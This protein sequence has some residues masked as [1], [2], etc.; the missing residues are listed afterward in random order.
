MNK[1]L[2]VFLC[3]PLQ[4]TI[5]NPFI[6]SSLSDHRSLLDLSLISKLL[7][8][9]PPTVFLSF[10]SFVAPCYYNPSFFAAVSPLR[11]QCTPKK[12][13]SCWTAVKCLNT[14]C[15]SWSVLLM[16]P[17]PDGGVFSKSSLKLIYLINKSRE[18]WEK[19][20][21]KCMPKGHINKIPKKSRNITNYLQVIRHLEMFYQKHL[22]WIKS[23]LN[24]VHHFVCANMPI[25]IFLQ[26]TVALHYIILCSL[27]FFTTP[28]FSHLCIQFYFS[29]ITLTLLTP[30]LSLSPSPPHYT[31]SSFSQLTLYPSLIFTVIVF[32]TLPLSLHNSSYHSSSSPVISS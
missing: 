9:I 2:T 4:L 6:P 19:T 17:T 12:I 16:T 10:I 5:H 20:F 13:K 29:F 1:A 7:L 24:F 11:L 18:S 30:H 14:Q 8:T 26:Y 28:R 21:K 32:L 25:L 22:A 23:K 31:T 27:Q 15:A 3:F